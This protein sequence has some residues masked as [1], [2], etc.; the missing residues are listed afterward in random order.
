MMSKDIIVI[1]G[2]GGVGKTTSASWLALNFALNGLNVDLV[3]IDPLHSLTDAFQV[4]ED[5][6]KGKKLSGKEWNFLN[7]EITLKEVSPTGRNISDVKEGIEKRLYTEWEYLAGKEIINFYKSNDDVMIIDTDSLEGLQRLLNY[8]DSR[9]SVEKEVA[10]KYLEAGKLQDLLKYVN[11]SVVLRGTEFYDS[12]KNADSTQY[13][14]ALLESI[15]PLDNYKIIPVT[16]LESASEKKLIDMLSEKSIFSYK[17]IINHVK[18]NRRD[19]K[20]ISYLK[21]YFPEYF[22]DSIL[23]YEQPFE[24][25]GIR[26]LSLQN[27]SEILKK[28]LVMPSSEKIPFSRIIGVFGKGG[29]GK[30]TVACAL[31][32]RYAHLIKEKDLD[33]KVII[34]SADARS[35]LGDILDV[36]IKPMPLEIRKWEDRYQQVGN[37]PLYVFRPDNPSLFLEEVPGYS[38]MRSMA[39]A[40]KDDIVII[41]FPTSGNVRKNFYQA[42]PSDDPIENLIDKI[43]MQYLKI[44]GKNDEEKRRLYNFLKDR[45]EFYQNALARMQ[46]E[47][48]AVIVMQATQ[49]ALNETEKLV[50]LLYETGIVPLNKEPWFV[51]NK[52][53]GIPHYENES[54]SEVVNYL[55]D[56]LDKQIPSDINEYIIDIF[57]DD[58]RRSILPVYNEEPIGIEKLN[59]IGKLL[60]SGDSF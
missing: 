43:Y 59:E 8:I 19:L 14:L 30:S 29:Q 44:K 13:L 35:S 42:L 18:N 4:Y 25:F 47:G 11:S 7:G 17:I 34:A 3:S 49:T 27:P 2:K 1:T 52:F 58:D 16:T 48:T 50:S 39:L 24:P 36:E 9:F 41:D 21:K 26:L 55:I 23:L 15:N 60:V 20:K 40:R 22:K 6:S 5:L 51:I 38:S 46:E 57:T 10:E 53:K 33:K 28:D 54:S 12:L 31:A 32:V 37:L 56:E 45:R